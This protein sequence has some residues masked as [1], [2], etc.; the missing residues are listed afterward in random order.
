MSSGGGT[1]AWGAPDKNDHKFLLTL[2]KLALASVIEGQKICNGL[3]P[4]VGIGKI[5][6]FNLDP[7]F[8]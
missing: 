2:G 8:W 7:L 5:V 4:K 3:P 6:K 1:P